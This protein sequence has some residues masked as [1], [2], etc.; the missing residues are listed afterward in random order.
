MIRLPF[1]ISI[2]DLFL[3]ELFTRRSQLS[4]FEFGD[5]DGAPSL[6]SPVITPTHGRLRAHHMTAFSDETELR[7]RQ[8]GETFSDHCECFI[9]SHQASIASE[10]R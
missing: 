9:E 5:L 4:A 8:L 10:P 2:A 1:L 7:Q 6:S 3:I